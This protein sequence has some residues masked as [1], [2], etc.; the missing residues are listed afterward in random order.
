MSFASTLRRSALRFLSL[1]TL[2]APL[3]VASTFAV[4]CSAPAGDEDVGTGGTSAAA[5]VGDSVLGGDVTEDTLTMVLRPKEK[6]IDYG[7][8]AQLALSIQDGVVGH[9]MV[10]LRC[11]KSD[12]REK[13][14][15]LLTG[16]T[17]GATMEEDVRKNGW[18]LGIIWRSYDG[19]LQ[20]DARVR[21]NVEDKAKE[22]ALSFVRYRISPSMCERLASF[23]DEYKK[24][25][26]YKKYGLVNRPRMREGAGCTGFG[27][28]FLEVAGFVEK[29]YETAWT[30]TLHVQSSLIGDPDNG[31]K[32]S[33][34][35]L[36][37]SF[38]WARE[39]EAQREATYWEP[40]FIH[41]WIVE[42]ATKIARG[43]EEAPAGAKVVGHEKA[44][45]LEF[46]RRTVEAPSEAIFLVDKT[47]E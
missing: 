25:E 11:Q 22:G 23:A 47:P 16:Q 6:A 31:K 32:V 17:G 46:D 13:G 5:S 4:G 42:R 14:Y 7:S 26:D 9:T 43:D 15:Y 37:T 8:P 40:N 35:D 28:G 29:D 34:L 27:M 45:G 18:G 3:V 10:E 41:K 44:K 38:R 39:G 20:D 12:K 30:K 24:N 21:G 33:V 36:G 2:A 1:A 19:Y